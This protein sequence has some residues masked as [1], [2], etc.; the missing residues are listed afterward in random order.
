[1]GRIP[2]ISTVVYAFLGILIACIS[3]FWMRKF[4]GRLSSAYP[5]AGVDYEDSAGLRY[6]APKR[7]K[8]ERPGSL[9]P[10]LRPS[11]PYDPH[12]PY[13]LRP[14]LRIVIPYYSDGGKILSRPLY[15]INR[16]GLRGHPIPP[17]RNNPTIRIAILGGSAVFGTGIDEETTIPCLLQQALE[18]RGM[19]DVVVVNAGLPRANLPL[20]VAHYHWLTKHHHFQFDV[21]VFWITEFAADFPG[22]AA[23]EDE[24][25]I[26]SEGK[27]RRYMRVVP[28]PFDGLWYNY[29][30]NIELSSAMR[31]CW[32]YPALKRALIALASFSSSKTTVLLVIDDPYAIISPDHSIRPLPK[33][34][35]QMLERYAGVCSR[36]ST[37]EIDQQLCYAHGYKT[38]ASLFVTRRDLVPVKEKRVLVADH[39]ARAIIDGWNNR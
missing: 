27:E 16:Y 1:M 29:F 14:S 2:R 12:R 34:T 20:A 32:G 25:I 26:L 36:I 21:V 6:R 9:L 8:Q 11:E 38:P 33:Y 22:F 37:R 28:V 17:P 4:I 19:R 24:S 13:E 23:R 7:P 31:F 30:H 10:L 18:Q 35:F 39:M 5:L 3:G 15:R